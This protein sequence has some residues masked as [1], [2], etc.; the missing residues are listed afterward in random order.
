MVKILYIA[1]WGRSGT[2]I[3][4]NILGQQPG[5]FSSGEIHNLWQRGLHDLRDCGCGDR[6]VDCRVWRD[7]F[8]H[9]FGGIDRV[10]AAM[11]IK[12]QRSIRTRH[13]RRVLRAASEGRA[14]E[15]SY[16]SFLDRLYR[17]I[18]DSTGAR[19]IVDSS[20]FPVDGILASG[21]DG[22][23]TYVLH[24]TRD[25]RAVANSWQR[26][27]SVGDKTK[28]QGLL[29]RVGLVR[30]TVT[31]Q[32][33][34]HVISTHDRAAVGAN[35]YLRIKYEDWTADPQAVLEEVLGLVGESD[36]GVQA[37]RDVRTVDLR[38]THTAG[39]NPDRFRS[40]AVPIRIDDAWRSDLSATKR[41]VVTASAVPMLTRM[42]YAV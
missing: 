27:K 36:Q 8:D 39:G 7:V 41:A 14:S 30:S 22:Y 10:D 5:F 32:R 19:V 31:W 24:V 40:G 17:G 28:G 12:G 18:A 3:L 25:P 42:G 11:A 16:A 29:P 9:G 15:Y 37:L 20:K 21:L 38:P 13:A 34:N 4:D 33:Y 2:T 26:R 6:L 1:A 23:E 35:R